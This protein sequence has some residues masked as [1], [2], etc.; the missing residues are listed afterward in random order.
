[1]QLREMFLSQLERESAAT[2]KTI[3][4]VPEGL[5]DWKP[6]EKSMPLGYLASLTATMPGWASFMIDRDQLDL[7]DPSSEEFRTVPFENRDDLL[8]K[9][10]VGL[11]RSR[12]ALARTTEEHL[13]KPLRFAMD[14]KVLYEAPRHQ[15][16]SD[17][18][19]CHMAHHRGQLT[20]YLRLIDA[21]VPAIYGPSADEM[22]M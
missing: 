2:L 10:E 18:L 22:Q 3:G 13:I 14:G 1:M 9:F 11:I 15:A 5:N 4:R 12:E 6:H 16:I 17:S 19:F 7:H 20:V 21:K 8:R